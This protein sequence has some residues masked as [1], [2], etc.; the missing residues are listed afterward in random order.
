MTEA[1]LWRRR[2]GKA[3][4][5][6]AVSLSAPHQS[7][8][9]DRSALMNALASHVIHHARVAISERGC[10]TWAL[11]GGSTP[12]ELY[13]LMARP[14][15]ARQVD[16]TRV[17]IFWGDERCVPP[18]APDSNYKMAFDAL[19]QHVPI[20]ASR[21]HRMAGELAPVV[22]AERYNHDLQTAFA[23]A[24][25]PNVPPS[26]DLILLGMGEDGHTASL[27][28][29]TSVLSERDQWTS[30]VQKG[31][32]WRLTLTLPVLN[33]AR[34]VAF[35]VTGA[36]KRAMLG[37]VLTAATDDD[38][39]WPAAHVRPSRGRVTWFIDSDAAPGTRSVSH[40]TV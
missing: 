20:D 31:E 24:E 33:A 32:Q 18:D 35:L 14:E 25:Y 23:A 7:V 1:I 39:P 28:P 19:L 36:N 29:G 4:I 12:R 27:F 10:F 37:N 21:V 22:A 38:A 30:A 40:P 15:F 17:E 26:F 8:Y 16:W 11:A 6:R 3:C 34:E 9:S 2:S 13:Q 5:G